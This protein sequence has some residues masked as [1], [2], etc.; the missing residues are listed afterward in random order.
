[1]IRDLDADDVP[2]RDGRLDADAAGGEGHREVVGE[3]LDAREL[4]AGV[5]AHLVLGDDGAGV[6]A[7]DDGRDLEAAELLLDDPD[8][9]GVVV[10]RDVRGLGVG[11]EQRDARQRPGALVRQRSGG[12]AEVHLERG[13]R[14]EPRGGDHRGTD[15]PGCGTCRG[16]RGSQARR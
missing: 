6:R 13:V 16:D 9:A 1:V 14:P 3:T 4:H 2:S 10:E 7:D 12:Q 11:V 8:V 5:R 15:R